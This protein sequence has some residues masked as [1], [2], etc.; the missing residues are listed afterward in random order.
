M[1]FIINN[2]GSNKVNIPIISNEFEETNFVSDCPSIFENIESLIDVYKHSGGKTKLTDNKSSKSLEN[3]YPKCIDDDIHSIKTI[4]NGLNTKS[5]VQAQVQ[6]Q[7]QTQMQTHVQA[8]MQS[9]VQ[10][11]VQVQTQVI[12]ITKNSIK[13]ISGIDGLLSCIIDFIEP[14]SSLLSY[15]SKMEKINKFKKQ[16]LLDLNDPSHRRKTLYTNEDIINYIKNSDEKM[17][18]YLCKLLNKNIAIRV[19]SEDV[20]YNLFKYDDTLDCLIIDKVINENNISVYTYYKTETFL[21]TITE[22]IKQRIIQYIKDGTYTKIE[23]MLVK[24]LKDLANSLEV[25]SFYKD[26]EN[27][28]KPYLKN[29]LKDEIKKKFDLYK[30]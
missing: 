27:K 3:M 17:C 11:Q 22:I 12:N 9:Q 20:E 25:P 28:K 6:A 5:H 24:E 7:M 19:I 2:I 13:Y 14:T 1:E 18:I 15:E 4:K 16:M 23:S 30:Q 26:D 29:E 10:S 21:N 8:Q